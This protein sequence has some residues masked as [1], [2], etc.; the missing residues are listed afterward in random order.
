MVDMRA[1]IILFGFL[2]LAGCGRVPTVD[3]NGETLVGKFVEGGGVAAF[4]GVPFAEPPV[5][6]LRWRAPQ[7]L[8]TKLPRRETV[9]FA[10]ACMQSMRILDWYRYLAELFGDSRDYY[11][12][13]EVS[14]DCLYLNVWTPT[15]GTDAKLPVLVWIHGGSNRSGW[16]YELSY[17]GHDLAK[18]DVVVVSVAYRQGLFGFFSHP[19]L[20]PDEPVANFG[21][22]D[23]IASLEWI[24]AHIDRFGG[25]SSRVTVFGESAGAQNIVAL[26]FAK[27]AA[28][29][30]QRAIG[31]STAG[32]GLTR[33]STLDA[34]Q[35]RAG[36]FAR[37]VGADPADLDALRG[38][39]ADRL[40]AA[41]EKAFA[42]Y[43]HSP[44]VDGQLFTQSV[45]DSIRDADFPDIPLILGTNDHEFYD[46]VADD[47]DWDSVRERAASLQY[48]D[49]DAALAIVATETDPQR[50]LDRLITAHNYLCTARH[51]A[52]RM[53]A[54]GHDAWLYHF[55]RVREDP[56]AVEEL[57]AYHGAE[58]PYIFGVHDAYMT[59]N[60]TD[61]A[62]E[63]AM[64]RYWVQFAA[65]GAP[66]GPGVPPWPRFVDPEQAVQELGDRV[67]TKRA[68]EP[69]LCALF[70]QWLADDEAARDAV[71][72]N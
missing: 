41:Y 40:L 2:A 66:N 28:G 67:F 51:M 69:E 61:L 57:G 50:A 48:M 20:N 9:D 54:T 71:P 49:G 3:A 37:L 65:T 58:Y 17:H 63:D 56:A 70:E 4:L 5:G 45:W 43:Y 30:F 44:A 6:E 31:Q 68:P 1:A 24:Q 12:D 7:P 25:D 27:P 21:Y 33:M 39:P 10:P 35:Q 72:P 11:D 26:M 13:L 34:E 14:E 52:S 60:A 32:F 19:A 8:Q 18:R 59:T 16:S 55:T 38:M 47:T 62:L 29:L 46:S 53:T 42:D 15:L 23:L 36:E 22:W 64:Q